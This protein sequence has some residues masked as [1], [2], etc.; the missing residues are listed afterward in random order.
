[1]R[2][3]KQTAS[4]HEASSLQIHCSIATKENGRF[5]AASGFNKLWTVPKEDGNLSGEFRVVWMP[6]LKNDLAR[7]TAIAAQV[8]NMSGLVR[9][10]N[11][12]GI[13]VQRASFQEAWKKI[14]PDDDVPAEIPNTLAFKL[15]PL[16]YGTNPVQIKE[17]ADAVGWTIRPVRPL[18]PRAWLVTC[19]QEPPQSIL[20]WN[21]HPIL[22]VQLQSRQRQSNQSAIVAGPR[23]TR[24]S[25][26]APLETD[27]WATW[28][29]KHPSPMAAASAAAP[30]VSRQLHGPTEEKFQNQEQRLQ[31]LEDQMSKIRDAQ[32][33]QKKD[34]QQVKENVAG[35]EQRLGEQIN[36]AMASVKA[37]L[38]SSF[39]QAFNQQSQNFDNNL[40]EFKALLL[41][42][43]RKKGEPGDEDMSS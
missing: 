41:Q 40:R 39:S 33:E 32:E 18:G 35:T 12:L 20:A 22:P 11:S 14:Y 29:T 8:P 4:I 21:G 28:L 37:E 1:M 23:M 3:G 10:R 27:P 24:D 42:T 30:V 13:R 15:E 2:R 9:G 19:G 31:T 7:L 34:M 16:P 25:R 43:K 36:T 26:N 17:W 5:L 38:A 6:H